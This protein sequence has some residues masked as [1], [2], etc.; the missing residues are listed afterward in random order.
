M[1]KIA[2]ERR[3]PS[4]R[5]KSLQVKA[6][7]HSSYKSGVIAMKVTNVKR[8][9]ERPIVSW[10]K[11]DRADRATPSC[12]NTRARDGEMAVPPVNSIRPIDGNLS[13]LSHLDR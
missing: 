3:D 12:D 7:K 1:N 2:I 5:S 6:F 9:I 4:T 10:L 8:C 11:I 13:F